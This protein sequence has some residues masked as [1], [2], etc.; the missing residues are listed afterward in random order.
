MKK[1]VFF[2]ISLLLPMLMTA[3]V[4]VG[5]LLCV[6]GNDTLTVHPENYT[7]GGIGVVFYVD[8]TGQHG[9]ALHPQVQASGIYWSY[10]ND[11][12]WGLTGWQ[13]VREAIYDLD[14]YENT[15]FIRAASQYDHDRYPGAWAVDYEHGWYWPA[16]GQ[17]NILYGSAPVVNQS[18]QLIGGTLLQGPWVYWS[19]SV[20]GFDNDCALYI[21]H[22]GRMGAVVKSRTY[23]PND[24]PMCVRSVRNF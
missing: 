3:Q 10:E 1:T 9:W 23:Y 7:S 24:I 2:I 18:L 12:P 20:Y 16:I 6:Q 21:N 17:L 11:L 4:K 13:S 19:S 5:D 8:E 14:G 22:A 15:G